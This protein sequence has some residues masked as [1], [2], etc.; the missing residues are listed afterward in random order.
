[1]PEFNA[2]IPFL[3]ILIPTRNRVKYLYFAIQS[4]LNIKSLNIEIIVSENYSEDDSLKVCKGFS[5]SRLRVVQPPKPLPMH[6]NWEFLLNLAR[7]K[8]VTFIGDD[9]A[10]MQHCVDH[11]LWLDTNF[12]QAEAVVSPRACYVWNGCQKEYGDAAVSFSFDDTLLWCDSKQKLHSALEGD[13]NYFSLPQMYSGGFHRMSLIERV[14]AS[15]SGV[16]FKS[17]T[18]DAYSALMACLHTYRYLQT[19]IPMTWVGSSP[20]KAVSSSNAEMKDRE[21]DFFGMHDSLTIHS[22]LGDLH[23][24]TL[25]LYLYE[26]YISAFPLTSPELLSME[27]VKSI[28]NTSV[29]QLRKQGREDAVLKLSQD[30]G[31]DIPLRDENKIYWIAT[32]FYSRLKSIMSRIRSGFLRTS[33]IFDTRK[34][35]KKFKVRYSSNSHQEHSNILSCDDLLA[36]TY[37]NCVRSHTIE[38]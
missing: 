8:W 10:V 6:E 30:L 12:P 27:K 28:F 23:A 21:A 33:S 4:A 22:A 29:R 14:K 13:I 19:E 1:M 20:H 3:S 9:D 35:S 34:P 36:E 2:N 5:D 16:Y 18:P 38:T 7:G 31:F 25:Q 37:S 24:G 15:Q 26:A 17:V 32:N 11:L